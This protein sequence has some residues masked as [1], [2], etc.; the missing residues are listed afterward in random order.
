MQAGGAQPHAEHHEP[1]EAE[2]PGD[3]P[4][5]TGGVGVEERSGGQAYQPDC[6]GDNGAVR[7]QGPQ[8]CT[9]GSFVCDSFSGGLG[10][11]SR[12]S[13]CIGFSAHE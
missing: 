12:E 7:E 5:D 1:Y 11:A 8:Y 3:E 6:Y 2:D 10:S 4:V 9:D 13:V